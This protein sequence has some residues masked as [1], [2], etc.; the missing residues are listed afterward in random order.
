MSD[1]MTSLRGVMTDVENQLD[2]MKHRWQQRMGLGKLLI[3][4]YLGHGTKEKFFLKGR[5]L[6]DKG[7]SQALDND[8]WLVNLHN[9]YL[10]YQSDEIPGATVRLTFGEGVHEIVTDEEGYFLFEFP[11]GP[12]PTVDDV[13]Y[14]MQLELIDYPG[15]DQNTEE[16]QAV[17]ATGKVLVPPDNSQFGVI[18]DIDDTVL[19]TDV[20]N[21][22]SMARN[23]FFN[24]A[25]TRLP[26]EGVAAFYQA[27]RR[28]GDNTRTNPIFYVSSSPWNLYDMIVDFF[29]VRGIPMGPLFLL[30]LG[31]DRTKLIT[32]SHDVHK[33][34]AIQT[35]LDTHKNL[36]FILIGDSGQRDP[37][38]YFD[39]VDKNPGRIL[40]VYI[41]DVTREHRDVVVQSVGGEMMKRK[42][43]MLAV[44]DTMAAAVHASTNGYIN[45]DSLPSIGE[46]TAE[47]K[48][49][50]TPLEQ[51]LKPQDQPVEV[52]PPEGLT[53]EDVKAN[54]KE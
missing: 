2:G 5:V 54:A 51:A 25:R 41:R 37:E 1:L 40:S 21:V 33:I 28:G 44:K 43:E 36:K 18:S 14:E 22:I 8:T 35:L 50:P 31:L 53:P 38:I 47:D 39:I 4:P 23:T 30:D 26:F 12:L 13:W 3:T 17:T 42:V 7:I 29:F 19:M 52:K 45:P 46:E 11:P 10:R 34:K 15:K 16:P 49:A 32:P 48:Q 9:M 24:N 20:L 6:R 27:L